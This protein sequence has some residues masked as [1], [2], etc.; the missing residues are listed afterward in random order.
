MNAEGV[1]STGGW[2][3]E[4][5]LITEV[6]RN[7]LLTVYLMLILAPHLERATPPSLKE[8]GTERKSSWVHSVDSLTKHKLGRSNNLVI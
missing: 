5:D 1:V 3:C 7:S 4:F 6:S 2:G 8:R